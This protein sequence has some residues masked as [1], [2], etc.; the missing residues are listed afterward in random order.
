MTYTFISIP[1]TPT[2]DVVPWLTYNT[3]WI[4]LNAECIEDLPQNNHY[5][6][7]NVNGPQLPDFVLLSSIFMAGLIKL[8]Y[9]FIL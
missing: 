2:Q 5:L 6:K 8:L 3:N 9:S 4:I 7:E 1:V